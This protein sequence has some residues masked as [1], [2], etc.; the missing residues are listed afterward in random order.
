MRDE[1][2]LSL[3]PIPDST[4]DETISDQLVVEDSNGNQLDENDDEIVR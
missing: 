3:I 1:Y 4:D 2:H